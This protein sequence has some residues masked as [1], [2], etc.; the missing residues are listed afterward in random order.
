VSTEVAELQVF[1][2]TIEKVLGFIT[3]Y[4]LYIRMKMR[5][6]VV[7]EQ[8]QWILLY[9]QE[10]SVD[11]WKENILKDLEKELLEYET[12]GEFLADIKKEFGGGDE[13]TVKVAELK[14][15]E[16]EEK[17]IKKFVQEFRRAAR[18]SRYEGRPLIEEFKRDMNGMICQRLIKSE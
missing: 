5:G 9:V 8:I 1:N 3:A 4:K 15:I 10:R 7:E 18:S 2:E 12:A 16:Q 14:R 13:E 11:I 6:I 17:T